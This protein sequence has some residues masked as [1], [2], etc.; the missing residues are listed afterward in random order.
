MDVKIPPSQRDESFPLKKQINIIVSNILKQMA[1][2]EFSAHSK[3]WMW[4]SS[5]AMY[6]VKLYNV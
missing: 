3:N 4:D 6:Y 2:V 1:V 5:G